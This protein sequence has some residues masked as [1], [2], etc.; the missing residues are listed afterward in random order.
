MQCNGLA[1]D[2]G[3]AICDR[4]KKTIPHMQKIRVEREREKKKR[5][6]GND[7]NQDMQ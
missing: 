5:T 1:M 2:D 3:W 7:D 6:C 4:K